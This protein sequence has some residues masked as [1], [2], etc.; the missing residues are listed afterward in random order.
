MV[1]FLNA[2]L[3]RFLHKASI[4]FIK[5]L[6]QWV[7]AAFAWN[8]QVSIDS[9][10]SWDWRNKYCHDTA[11][12]D[13]IQVELSGY[14]HQREW[15][16]SWLHGSVLSLCWLSFSPA[17]QP[18]KSPHQTA[19]GCWMFCQKS[20]QLRQT[21]AHKGPWPGSQTW[22]QVVCRRKARK[23]PSLWCTTMSACLGHT[24]LC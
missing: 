4:S 21:N 14:C 23:V 10:T 3:H 7:H 18:A 19:M 20:S 12:P 9:W 1:T 5:K 15:P 2:L 17:P 13:D 24:D 16:S 6:T 11:R 8:V 22:G